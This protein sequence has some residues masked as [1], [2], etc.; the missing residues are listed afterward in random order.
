MGIFH[1]C[2]AAGNK[3]KSLIVESVQYTKGKQFN[4]NRTIISYQV[5]EA[6]LYSDWVAT[7]M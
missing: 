4:N 5:Q 3:K 2:L 6:A 1:F 7:L